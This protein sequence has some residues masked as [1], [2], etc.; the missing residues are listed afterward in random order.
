MRSPDGRYVVTYNGEIYNYLEIK[1]ELESIGEVLHSHS[2]TEVLL[3]A[4]KV[5]GTECIHRFRGMF[6]FVIWDAQEKLA[7]L[8]RD[9]CGEKPLFYQINHQRL[10]FASE[11]KALIPLLN[12]RP[13]LDPAVI[14]MYLHYQYVP[15]PSTLLKGVYK[16]AAGHSVTIRMADW[17]FAPQPY[18]CVEE[19]NEPIPPKTNN[20]L[21]L[22]RI[23][24]ALEDAVKMTLRSD[25]PVG[26]ALSGGIDS[27]MIAALAQ[28]TI[29]SP[30][31][32]FALA[33]PG[34]LLMMSV[35]RPVS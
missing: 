12:E 16:L 18:W 8:G 4:Y 22:P 24:D 15:E 17:K 20:T 23:R 32:L 14:D 7:F 3:V 27:G 1:A 5:W 2:D 33:I 19:V 34:D 30:C 21:I 11:L 28:K 25:V 9:R 13:E 6:A 10:V 35:L 29:L 26:V 31:M